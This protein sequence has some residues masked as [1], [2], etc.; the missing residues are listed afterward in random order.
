MLVI[1]G[2]DSRF[3]EMATNYAQWS[4]VANA[5]ISSQKLMG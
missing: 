3:I 1:T 2:P 5:A 4:I